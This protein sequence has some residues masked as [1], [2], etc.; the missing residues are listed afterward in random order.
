M[1]AS[2]PRT[3]VTAVSWGV[4]RGPLVAEAL[5]LVNVWTRA[6]PRGPDRRGRP[7]PPDQG[8]VR[9]NMGNSQAPPMLLSRV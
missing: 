8:L 3:R 6:L 1:T 5:D 4:G 9:Q 2:P 7:P